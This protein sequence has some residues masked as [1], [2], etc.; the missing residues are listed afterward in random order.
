MV[1]KGCQFI[2]PWGLIGTPWKV[3]VPLHEWL[4]CYMVNQARY[5]SPM[6]VTLPQTNSSPL[7]KR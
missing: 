3:L 5:T 1:A 2:V 6:D 4:I 7:K